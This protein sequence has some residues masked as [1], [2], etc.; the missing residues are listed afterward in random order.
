M[1]RRRSQW[2]IGR[3]EADR[4]SCRGN[5]C[6]DRSR[7][8]IRQLGRI[9]RGDEQRDKVGR[10][11]ACGEEKDALHSLF[12][13]VVGQPWLP[14]AHASP[15][16]LPSGLSKLASNRELLLGSQRSGVVVAFG[17][18]VLR[19]RRCR[20][21]LKYMITIRCRANERKE[22]EEP[23]GFAAHEQLPLEHFVAATC[24]KSNRVGLRDPRNDGADLLP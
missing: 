3:R 18:G 14:Q 17:R 9:Q 1:R 20:H 5:G 4:L 21:R 7:H 12:D 13:G 2:L 24:A 10:H 8:H 16:Q 15:D 23:E 19:T 6:R 11:S 22:R